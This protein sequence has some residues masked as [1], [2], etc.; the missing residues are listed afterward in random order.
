M[1]SIEVGQILPLALLSSLGAPVVFTLVTGVLSLTS[2]NFD[3]IL[4]LMTLVTAGFFSLLL[5][6]A[7]G[8][9]IWGVSRLLHAR[10]IR[11][12]LIAG[13]VLLGYAVLAVGFFGIARGGIFLALTACNLILLLWLAT[14]TPRP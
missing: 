6:L 4:L 3:P 5:T 13:G 11:I 10:L 9:L 14:R 7:T 12:D 1:K 2:G 8:L